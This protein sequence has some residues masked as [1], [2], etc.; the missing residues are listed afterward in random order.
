[1]AQLSPSLF[2]T[3]IMMPPLTGSKSLNN[4]ADFL[5]RKTEYLLPSQI[6]EIVLKDVGEEAGGERS[7]LVLLD[8]LALPNI[9][10][11]FLKFRH[12]S[13][14]IWTS[15]SNFNLTWVIVWIIDPSL[16]RVTSWKAQDFLLWE[17]PVFLSCILVLYAFC[18]NP[19]VTLTQPQ[20]NLN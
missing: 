6:V 17:L 20:L 16:A 10:H 4:P 15:G 5:L 11:C 2:R 13:C 12:C 9:L 19:N 14:K 3:L 18:Q 1:M 8:C 7:H